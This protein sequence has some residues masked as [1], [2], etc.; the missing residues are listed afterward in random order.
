MEATDEN[1]SRRRRKPRRTTLLTASRSN[2][3]AIFE[4]RL[5]MIFIEPERSGKWRTG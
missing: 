2:R 4:R 1:D 5:N 3:L